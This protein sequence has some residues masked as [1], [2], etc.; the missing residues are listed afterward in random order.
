MGGLAAGWNALSL[1]LRQR[2][3]LSN[4]EL[5]ALMFEQL[6]LTARQKE[7]LRALPHLARL[8]LTSVLPARCFVAGAVPEL[9]SGAV[10]SEHHLWVSRTCWGWLLWVAFQTGLLYTRDVTSVG[11]V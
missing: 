3:L 1:D 4:A 8:G 7:G 6:Q 5:A 10:G 9:A 2:D 11:A